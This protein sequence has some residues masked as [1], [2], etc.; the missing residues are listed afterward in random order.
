[1]L[2]LD[3]DIKRHSLDAGASGNQSKPRKSIM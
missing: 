3:I 1:M 2:L